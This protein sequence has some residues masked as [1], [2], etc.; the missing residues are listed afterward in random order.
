MGLAMVG[1]QCKQCRRSFTA[2]TVPGSDNLLFEEY[3]HRCE[4][5]NLDFE[6]FISRAIE[7]D[8]LLDVKNKLAAKDRLEKEK[9]Y[10]LVAAYELDAL[11]AAAVHKPDKRMFVPDSEFNRYVSFLLVVPEGK[12]KLSWCRTYFMYRDVTIVSDRADE[13]LGVA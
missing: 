8:P 1:A 3:C 4:E 13:L 10:A 7:F 5:K 12:H 9:E 11:Y 2:R 6:T